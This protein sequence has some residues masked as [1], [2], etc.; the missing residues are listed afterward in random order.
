MI[1]CL[2][3]LGVLLPLDLAVT[4]WFFRMMSLFVPD[5]FLSHTSRFVVIFWATIS[6]F[7]HI[8]RCFSRRIRECFYK[9][10]WNFKDTC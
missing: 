5:L 2:L 1:M 6:N 10:I 8:D 9:Q 4:L 7:I 3:K